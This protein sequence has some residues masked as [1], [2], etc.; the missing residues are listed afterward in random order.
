MPRHLRC[1]LSVDPLILHPTRSDDDRKPRVMRLVK[2][3]LDR[4]RRPQAPS[5][6]SRDHT[7]RAL[8][9]ARSE[10]PKVD[11]QP[12]YV[13]GRATSAPSE[14]SR[15]VEVRP[16]IRLDERAI[17][18]PAPNRPM[19]PAQALDLALRGPRRGQD[20]AASPL[21]P[22]TGAPIED[23]YRPEHRE[24]RP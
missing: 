2:R 1:T 14:R 17:E 7:A 11:G 22:S 10:P 16:E 3:L 13:V 9:T 15:D 4:W 12:L 19:S 21:A 5:G 24:P 18:D 23:P 8:F 20:P 6:A